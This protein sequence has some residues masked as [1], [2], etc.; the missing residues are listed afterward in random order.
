[1]NKTLILATVSAANFMAMLNISIVNVALPAMET[2]LHTDLS[3]LQWVVNA[4]TICLSALTL[5][6]G[7]LGDRFGRKRLFVIGI[8]GFLAGSV[9]C[10]LASDL[11][12][13]IT[14]RFVQGVAAA[15]LIPGSLSILA[16]TYTDPVERARK[17]GVWASLSAIAMVIGPVAGG[18]LIEYYD[19]PAIFWVSVP[20]GVIALIAALFTVP[21]SADPTHASLDPLGQSL[22]VGALGLL[23]YGLI[24]SGDTGWGD[25]VTLVG[26]GV[27]IALFAAFVAVELRQSR[28]MLPVRLFA[29]RNFATMNLASAALGFGPYAIYTFLSLF[30]QQAQNMTAIETGL[31]FVPMSLATAAVAPIAGR[32]MGRSGPRA[33]MLTGYL[34]SAV[35]LIGLVSLTPDTSYW[36]AIGWF[37]LMGAGMGFSMTP[38]TTAAVTAVPRERSGIASA[39]INTTRQTGMALGV[40]LL[41]SVVAA[42]DD[43]TTGFHWAALIAGAVSL[44]AVVAVLANRTSKPSSPTVLATQ[45]G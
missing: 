21:E 29:D 4:F 11:P 36:V 32:W 3:G 25:A 14:G 23:T 18:A 2:D 16:Q 38:T 27:G 34:T 37:V 8:A 20:I 45:P 22:A 39:T 26:V 28:P 24:R 15:M 6:G 10:A 9:L 7:A 30:M 44:L 13:L 19:W 17:I 1:M 35:G 42:G 40:A 41:G 5:T 43:F 33:P 31:A 12:T